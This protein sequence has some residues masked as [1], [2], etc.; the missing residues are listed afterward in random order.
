[1]PH[2]SLNARSPEVQRGPFAPGASG[3]APGPR[4]L[5]SSTPAPGFAG[6]P[7]PLGPDVHDIHHL[8]GS[9]AGSHVQLN[10]APAATRAF[11]VRCQPSQTTHTLASFEA[12]GGLPSGSGPSGMACKTP[13]KQAS[14]RADFNPFYI[15]FQNP[16][17]TSGKKLSIAAP[18]RLS[19]PVE[20]R[21]LSAPWTSCGN[22]AT[23]ATNWAPPRAR[24]SSERKK[25]GAVVR[26]R[27]E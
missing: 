15:A 9:V 17:K 26:P 7:L 20:I 19:K 24:A 1:M 16:G 22:E 12:P 2:S 13:T 11:L 6:A 25:L 21:T 14:Q 27:E 10:G 23:R 4:L 3:Q 18:S 8:C 5:V